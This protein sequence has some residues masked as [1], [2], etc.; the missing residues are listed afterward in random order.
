[1]SRRR[2]ARGRMSPLAEEPVAEA[3]PDEDDGTPTEG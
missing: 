2:R 3:A 1:M